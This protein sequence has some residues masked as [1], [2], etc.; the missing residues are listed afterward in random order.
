MAKMFVLN[1]SKLRY[2]PDGIYLP[3]RCITFGPR[4]TMQRWLAILGM[5][6]VLIDLGTGP[7]WNHD[8]EFQI[9]GRKLFEVQDV[10]YPREIWREWTYPKGRGK[11]F[12]FVWESIARK[13]DKGSV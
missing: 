10:P 6:E 2:Y 4:R 11:I 8:G 13:I 3:E 1:D 9:W 5:S 7:K 12:R